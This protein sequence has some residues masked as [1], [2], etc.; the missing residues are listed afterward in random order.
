MAKKKELKMTSTYALII[1]K[2]QKSSGKVVSKAKVGLS[3]APRTVLR[4]AGHIAADGN[5]GLIVN[6]SIKDV[7]AEGLATDVNAY[8]HKMKGGAKKSTRKYVRKAVTPV[9]MSILPGVDKQLTE[10]VLDIKG[11]VSSINQRL[12]NIESLLFRLVSDEKVG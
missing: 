10:S 9:N 3:A 8:W 7:T 12:T 11:D 5:G 1:A 6:E 4:R 2:L